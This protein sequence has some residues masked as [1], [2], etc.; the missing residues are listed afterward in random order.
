MQ[1]DMQK[2]LANCA[3]DKDLISHLMQVASRDLAN[4]ECQAYAKYIE[5]MTLLGKKRGVKEAEEFQAAIDKLQKVVP[6][7]FLID[8]REKHLQLEKWQKVVEE[9]MV[10]SRTEMVK[11]NHHLEK[12]KEL[13]LEYEQR[14][15]GAAKA[16]SMQMQKSQME[17]RNDVNSEMSKVGREVNK[18]STEI[19][20]QA[21]GT[22]EK[23]KA[24]MSAQLD[25]AQSE[26]KK[27]VDQMESKRE[28]L[29]D[30][31]KSAG[32]NIIET[33]KVIAQSSNAQPRNRRGRRNK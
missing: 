13:A 8:I 11:M 15:K 29:E 27:A 4:L 28:M 2:A 21:L 30:L 1:D 26:L 14:M 31:A 33:G 23:M 16:A 20:N 6:D 22:I 18:T 24:D 7:S 9:K 17:I 32:Q 25:T 5:G 19:T 12:F 3:F 10:D